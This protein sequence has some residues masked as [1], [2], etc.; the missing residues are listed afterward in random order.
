MARGFVDIG[1]AVRLKFTDLVG[2]N[3]EFVIS[4]NRL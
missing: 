1:A 3:A 2:M 4:G